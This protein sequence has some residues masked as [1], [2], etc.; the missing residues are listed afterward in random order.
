M[1]N[2]YFFSFFSR[3][4]PASKIS[5]LD[6][7]LA[8]FK[9]NKLR[10]AKLA[11]EESGDYRRFLNCRIY[12]GICLLS[13]MISAIEKASFFHTH[14]KMMLFCPFTASAMG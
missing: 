5:L 10:Y 13:T 3:T 6:L 2:R 9:Y 14:G 7:Q 11:V 12:S 4:R 1:G 8:I